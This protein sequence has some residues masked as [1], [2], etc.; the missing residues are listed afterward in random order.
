MIL[1][2][3]VSSIRNHYR[4]IGVCHFH[5]DREVVQAWRHF[6]VLVLFMLQPSGM[7]HGEQS[8]VHDSGATARH[9]GV[10]V[11]SFFAVCEHH[12]LL[13]GRNVFRTIRRADP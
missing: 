1:L 7:R 8:L 12:G 2:A 4:V 9:E 11:P 10:A 3:M 6:D 13:S 5:L